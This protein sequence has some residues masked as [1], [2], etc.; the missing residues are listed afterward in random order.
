MRASR[1]LMGILLVQT[2]ASLIVPTPEAPPLT[3]ALALGDTIRH[4]KRVV[5]GYVTRLLSLG[6]HD[7]LEYYGDYESY[8]GVS[9]TGCWISMPV[10]LSKDELSNQS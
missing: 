5:G 10:V 3:N 7:E 6:L 4:L 2:A 8:G 1:P 9:S